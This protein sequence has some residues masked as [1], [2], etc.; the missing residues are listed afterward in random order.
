[1][2]QSF[3]NHLMGDKDF[4]IYSEDEGSTLE[5]TAVKANK[6]FEVPAPQRRL[7]HLQGPFFLDCG[8]RDHLYNKDIEIGKSNWWYVGDG[9]TVDKITPDLLRAIDIVLRQPARHDEFVC[10]YAAA[11]IKHYRIWLYGSD[12]TSTTKGYDALMRSAGRWLKYVGRGDIGK[13][14]VDDHLKKATY[15]IEREL[16]RQIFSK[17]TRIARQAAILNR[18]V[19]E[20]LD[21]YLYDYCKLSLHSTDLV[22]S[23]GL[24]MLSMRK[25][26]WIKIMV[27]AAL[28]DKINREWADI[29]EEDSVSSGS[30]TE[31][32]DMVWK[33]VIRARLHE[34]KTLQD[35]TREHE[36]RIVKAPV[37][38][39]RWIPGPAGD[40][41]NGFW[42][43]D[44]HDTAE[45]SRAS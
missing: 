45:R 32:T 11:V 9:N 19:A 12:S 34:R 29:L 28:V 39:E 33:M 35:S 31:S 7:S 24:I 36:N 16:M 8:V 30:L 23:N 41:E 4:K 14:S 15:E 42:D 2:A 25:K 10:W 5:T 37:D 38:P 20:E 1:M 43:I 18:E 44:E 17:S 6:V 26:R 13:S 27:D 21:T 22:T 40:E 3:R